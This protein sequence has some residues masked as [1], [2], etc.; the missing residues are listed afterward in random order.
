MWRRLRRRSGRTMSGA[1]RRGDGESVAA[2]VRRSFFVRSR[3]ARRHV[4]SSTT[5]HRLSTPPFDNNDARPSHLAAMS[6]DADALLVRADK[7]MVTTL[8]RWKPDYEAAASCTRRLAASSPRARAQT[9][10]APR[11]REVRPRQR[12]DDDWHAARCLEQCATLAKDVGTPA[13]IVDYAERARARTSLANRQQRGAEAVGKIASLLD[14]LDPDAA[15]RLYDSAVRLLEDDDKHIY[16]P[17]STADPTPRSACARE[18]F[19][20]APPT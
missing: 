20:E 18:R 11:L 14:D 7:K 2:T 12:P 5:G 4:R 15:C 19:A 6:D 8:T 1:R 10:R 13:N 17:T 3:C 9:R 16:A